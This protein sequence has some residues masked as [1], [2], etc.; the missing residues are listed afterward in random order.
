MF[1]YSRQSVRRRRRA[2]PPS[3]P[4]I[5]CQFGLI[6]NQGNDHLHTTQWIQIVNSLCT[7]NINILHPTYYPRSLLQVIRITGSVA[8]TNLFRLYV[9]V[10]KILDY[11]KLSLLVD[12]RQGA[13]VC[14]PSG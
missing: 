1:I 9:E 7:A 10:L 11:N 12:D 13:A 2:A 4:N 14:R 8:Q 5:L 3:D 6:V